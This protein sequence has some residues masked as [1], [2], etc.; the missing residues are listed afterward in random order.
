[1]VVYSCIYILRKSNVSGVK[2]LL[3]GVQSVISTWNK[4]K[5]GVWFLLDRR[6]ERQGTG[7]GV[8]I[9][10]RERHGLCHAL[11]APVHISNITVTTSVTVAA[12]V[13][14]IATSTSATK[15]HVFP[16]ISRTPCPPM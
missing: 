7:K 16:P 10:V 4:R 11:P 14:V 2:P 5:T 13:V 9:V 15:Y 6:C 3:S 12:T 8:P 1:M